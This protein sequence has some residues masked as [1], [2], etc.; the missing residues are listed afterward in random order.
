[1]AEL[2]PKGTCDFCGEA[3]NADMV[4]AKAY[5]CSDFPMA[6]TGAMSYG[7][8]GACPACAQLVDGERWE[9]LEERMTTVQRRR[10]CFVA[11]PMLRQLRRVH[12]QQ[13]RLFRQHRISVVR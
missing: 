8:W 6:F 4:G 12:T 2:K 3:C 11:E 5:D 1:M 7:A 9:S 10:F 13:I